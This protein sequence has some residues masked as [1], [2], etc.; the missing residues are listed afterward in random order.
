MKLYGVMRSRATRA[1]W[2][3]GEAGLPHEHV[4]VIQAGRLADPLAADAPL[5]TASPA[6]LAVNPQGQVPALQD[7]DLVLT[8]SLA[9][10]LHVGRKSGAPLGPADLAEESAMINWALVGATGLEPGAIEILYTYMDG[11][12]ATEAG[13]ARIAAGIVSLS[14]SAARLEAHL[15]H[16]DWLVGGRFTVADICLAEILRY[17]QIHPAAL[18]PWPALRGWLARCQA[19]PAFAAMMARRDAEPA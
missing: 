13:R 4:P 15:A 1:V 17:A 9:I 3:L 12:Q 7:G 2:A 8:E 14:R 18:E 19:R 5:N 11:A 10:A 16:A 6:F